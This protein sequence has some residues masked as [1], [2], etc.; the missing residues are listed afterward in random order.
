VD[1]NLQHK[2]IALWHPKF[3][4]I[5]QDFFMMETLSKR[6]VCFGNIKLVVYIFIYAF[7]VIPFKGEKKGKNVF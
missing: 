6:Q 1:S 7:T 3:F 2:R 5:A 4:A